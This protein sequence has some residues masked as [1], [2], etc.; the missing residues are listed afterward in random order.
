MALG[1]A[2]PAQFRDAAIRRQLVPGAVV[3]FKALMD[4]G[5]IHEKRFVILHVDG[6]AMTCVINSEV[7]A[8]IRARPA[9]DRCQVGIDQATHQFMERDSFVDCSRV[10]SYPVDEVCQQLAANPAW[11]LGTITD[12]TRTDISS[13]LK[14]SNLI[15]PP[16][17]GLCCA[18]LDAAD[19]Q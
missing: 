9:M 18:S 2:F 1:S 3:K 5:Q 10:R 13:A 14:H 15:A 12:T 6:N 7:S 16:E 19:L 11:V 8:F 17:A 4:D